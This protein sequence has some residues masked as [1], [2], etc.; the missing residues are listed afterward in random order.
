MRTLTVIIHLRMHVSGITKE[1][2]IISISL[3]GYFSTGSSGGEMICEMLYI[4]APR[5]AKTAH[6]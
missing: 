6:Q 1:G 2:A 4:V 3:I 5:K